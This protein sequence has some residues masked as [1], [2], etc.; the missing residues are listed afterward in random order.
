MT[1]QAAAHPPRAVLGGWT[2]SQTLAIVAILTCAAVMRLITLVSTNEW[3]GDDAATGIMARYIEHGHFFVFIANSSYMGA[4]EQYLQAGVL[5]VLPTNGTTLRLVQVVLAVAVCFSVAVAGRQITGSAWG[6]I[7]AAS[8]F[9]VGPYF[10]IAKGI[11]SHGAYDTAQLVGVAAI[12]LAISLDPRHRR[13]RWV[14][15]ALGLCLGLAVWESYLALFLVIPAL[16]WAI[17]TSRK[18][19]SRLALPAIIGTLIG[20]APLLGYRIA[21]HS[22]LQLSVDANAT[23]PDISVTQRLDG[24]LSP[25]LGMFLGVGKIGAQSGGEYVSQALV[26]WIPPPLIVMAALAL[27]GA[28]AWSRRRGLVD[29]V[30]A[31]TRNREPIDIVFAGFLVFVLPYGYSGFTWLEYDPRYLFTLYPLL[32]IALAYGICRMPGRVSIALGIGLTSGL[33]ILSVVALRSD[34]YMN[35]VGTTPVTEQTAVEIA[36]TLGHL[37]VRSLYANYYLSTPVNFVSQGRIAGADPSGAGRFPDQAAA[38]R[39]DPNRA[40]ATPTGP[41]A[42]RLASAIR[43]SGATAKRIDVD[44]FAVFYHVSPARLPSDLSY[45]GD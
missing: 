6:G 9:A 25:V 33:L 30:T 26:P 15:A 10:N 38:V 31:R 42:E 28:G 17:G 20:A 40:Y 23:F 5:F 3:D 2:A 37:H 11:H 34:S 29:L 24:L 41:N 44:G 4:L 21:H 7:L 16:A 18:S 22:L 36:N 35:G 27:F 12:V 14:S 13:A 19:L 45:Y 32:A 1:V 39:G 8:I 43:D